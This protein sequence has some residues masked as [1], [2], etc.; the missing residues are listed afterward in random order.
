MLL[1]ETVQH[2]QLL[3]NFIK[4]YYVLRILSLSLIGT[5]NG[6]Y[7]TVP[8]PVPPPGL[9][10]YYL[11]DDFTVLTWIYNYNLCG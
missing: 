6:N 10:P 5:I 2:K 1:T 11:G 9:F 4:V 7:H 8:P 3:F